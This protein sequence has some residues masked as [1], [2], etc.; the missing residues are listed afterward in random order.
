MVNGNIVVMVLLQVFVD[1]E[2]MEIVIKIGYKFNVIVIFQYLKDNACMLEGDM[3]KTYIV[4]MVLWLRDHAKVVPIQ[5]VIY[6]E[7]MEVL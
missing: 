6:Q 7:T 4:L 5:T 2:D 1:Q 3:D